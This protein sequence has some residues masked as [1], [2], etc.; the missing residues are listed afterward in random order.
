MENTDTYYEGIERWGRGVVVI[1]GSSGLIGSQLIKHLPKQYTIIGLDNPG[2]PYPPN[3][4]ECIPMDITSDDS[5]QQAFAQIKEKHGNRISSF[6]HLS[7]YYD[8]SGR[9]SHLYEK[10]TVQGTERVLKFLKDFEVE[11]FVFSSS[12]L[13]YKSTVP[14]QKITEESSLNPTWDYPKSKVKTERLIHQQHG[15]IPVVILRMAGVYNEEGASI[16]IT[17]QIQRIYEKQLTSH[18]YPGNLSYGN[19]FIHLE[20]LVQAIMLAIQ[21]R[22]DLP[23]EVII[24]LGKPETLSYNQ[25]Q[26]TIAR[27]LYN[28]NWKT[29][30]IPKALA[31]VG[32]WVMNLFGDAFIKPWMIDRT[33][34]HAELNIS[35]AENLLGWEPKHS[36]K[37]TLPKMIAAL[38]ANPD[39]WYKENKLKK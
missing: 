8:F 12:L 3:E 4:A 16:P 31:I 38:K 5:V 21:K 1:T 27:L 26:Q 36:L 33:D 32:A 35:R 29:Y 24:N 34:D 7:A 9:P 20:D 17:N 18:F 11:Q 13:V 37:E 28:K 19:P 6:I 10:I 22:D 23:N 39:K 15:D 30:R 14:G 25:L 2:F